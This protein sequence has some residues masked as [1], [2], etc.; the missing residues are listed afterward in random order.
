MNETAQA[1]RIGA[2]GITEIHRQSLETGDIIATRAYTKNSRGVQFFTHSDVSHTILYTGIEQGAHWA[3]DAMPGR[4]VT[5]SQLGR[6]ITN[7]AYAV[8]FRHR[9]ATAEQRGRACQWAV[10]QALLNKPYDMHSAARLGVE[11]NPLSRSP[12]PLGNVAM[13]VVLGD[14]V[15][16]WIDRQGEDASFTCSELVFRA[17]EMAGA[18]LTSKPA[19]LVSPGV[20]YKTDRLVCLGRLV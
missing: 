7:V 12:G 16:A 2:R 18:P 11:E 8:V 5:R 13:L 6:K 10:S 14:Q 9:P 4:G 20:V 15:S 17:Y 1:E 19:H 3:V